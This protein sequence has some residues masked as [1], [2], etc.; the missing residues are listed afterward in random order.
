MAIA[1]ARLGRGGS[2]DVPINLLPAEIRT[3]QRMRR[4]FLG[5]VIASGA[6]LV[7]L[8]GITMLQRKAI[9][10]ARRD[11]AA[12]QAHAAT[13]QT[14]VGGLQHFGDIEAQLTAT[15]R[16]LATALVGD[17]SWSHFLTDLSQT[18]P[19][20]SWLLN[21]T[22]NA[23]PGLSPAG[24]ASLGTAKYSGY[25]TTFPG[26]SNWLTAMGRL[27]G[28]SFVYLDSGTKSKIGNTDVVSFSAD[29]N[30]TQSMLSGRC[31]TASSPCP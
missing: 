16:T 25:V 30:L 20:D 11:L 14:Q 17:V 6:L 2:I 15:R 19:G 8:A 29:A 1:S 26:L 28:L 23:Q 31:Q 12:E 27:E 9:S 18:M 10:D 7:I 13:L 24:D 3:A 5:V 4:V 21:V 22:L